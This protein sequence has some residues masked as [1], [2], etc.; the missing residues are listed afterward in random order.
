MYFR[1]V[2][3]INHSGC[4]VVIHDVFIYYVTSRRLRLSDDEDWCEASIEFVHPGI[5]STGPEEEEFC[6][7]SV[8]VTVE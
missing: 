8:S 6:D 3:N 7:P 1:L 4:T 2:K 5:L